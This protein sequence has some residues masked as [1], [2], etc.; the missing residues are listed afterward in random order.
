M[1]WASTCSTMIVTAQ[2]E[3]NII[4]PLDIKEHS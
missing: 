3:V 1:F 2:E 4:I